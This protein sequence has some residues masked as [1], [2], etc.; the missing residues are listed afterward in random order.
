LD[1]GFS[2]RWF[3]LPWFEPLWQ[4]QSRHTPQPD[5]LKGTAARG[6]ELSSLMMIYGPGFMA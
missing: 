3:S 4:D 5:R 2:R 6:G 1:H